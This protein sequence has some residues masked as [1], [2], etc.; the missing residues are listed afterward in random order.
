MQKKNRFLASA[1]E[2]KKTS[3]LTVCAM[4]AALALIL[5]QVATIRI[6]P[7]VRIGFSGIPNRMVDYLFG[8]VTGALFGGAL[9]IV[10]YLIKPDGAFFFGFTFN[11]MAGAFIYGCFYYKRKLTFRRVLTAK[12][13]VSVLINIL[14]NTLW[15]SM[16]YGKGFLVILPARALKNLIMWPIDTVIDYTV[17][18]QIDRIGV[19]RSFR[20][21]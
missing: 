2:L 12:L 17:L 19:F 3:A 21:G 10:K 16:L 18:R 20:Q 9:D 4:L 6:G 1:D 13:V 14:L 8:P 15:L 7:Y 5:S 11:A